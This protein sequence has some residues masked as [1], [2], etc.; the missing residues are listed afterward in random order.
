MKRLFFILSTMLVVSL[1]NASD[2]A[3][4]L[5]FTVPSNYF[6]YYLPSSCS[7]SVEIYLYDSTYRHNAMAAGH[8]D[9]SSGVGQCY[10]TPD[11]IKLKGVAVGDVLWYRQFNPNMDTNV[12]YALDVSILRFIDENTVEYYAHAPLNTIH[13][14][15]SDTIFITKDS[16]LMHTIP[17]YEVFFD[18][19][20]FVSDSFF[21][22]VDAL[23]DGKN[24]STFFDDK[25]YNL[26]KLQLI[27]NDYQAY[28]LDGIPYQTLLYHALLTSR[29]IYFNVEWAIL[30]E[31]CPWGR[32]S[33]LIF[34]ILDLSDST[35]VNEADAVG[36]NAAVWP[37]PARGTV[38]VASGFGLRSV[39]VFDLEGRLVLSRKVSGLSADIDISALPRGAYAV[40]ITTMVG[41]TTK[42]LL[43]E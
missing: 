40:R 18:S 25:E 30:H 32:N 19:S 43:V 17:L 2:M 36:R 42:K 12:D 31:S 16:V 15:F 9:M 37:N 29:N 26:C 20:I 11:V 5:I 4:S 35:V 33:I 24:D 6:N 38:S 10:Y 3:D 23:F 28:L 21:C 7:D 34:P 41:T 22:M 39:D 14:V 8:K 13:D 1:V 27:S